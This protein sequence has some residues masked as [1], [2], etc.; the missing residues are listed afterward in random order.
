MRVLM[1]NAFH[2][3]KG[4]VERTVFDETAW[5]GRA[6]HEVAHFAIQDARNVPSPFAKHFAPAADY[7]ESTPAW[8]QL[9]QLPRAI[10]S[11]PAEHALEG[12]LTAWRPDVAHVH[13]PSRYLTP[14]VIAGLERAR[15]PVVMTLHDFKPWC[16]NRVLFARGEV[17]ERCKGGQHWHAVSV[18]CVQRS[19]AKSLVGALEAYDHDRRGAYRPVRRWIAPSQ[20]VRGKA[21]ELGA[22]AA[23]VRVLVHGVT[24]AAPAAAGVPELPER[25]VLY[26]GRLADEKGVRM[27]PALARGIAPTPLVV[28][29]GGPL[30]GW[31]ARHAAAGVRTLGH[32][33]TQELAHVRARSAVVVVPSLF[34]ETF[35]YAVAEAQLDARAVIASRI[36]AL[37]EL[38]EHE[39][40]GLLVSP[41]DEPALVAAARRAL[42]EPAVAQRWGETAR[43]RARAAH[44]P[45]AHTRGLA[46]VYQEAMQG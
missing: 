11:A 6:G 28:A 21:V 30:A 36:G 32:L 22:D 29:G 33:G 24:P 5:L 45:E 46:A 43:A 40:S 4:G 12:L 16:T 23:R 14:S 42:A 2:W 8:R 13:A 35:G 27:L 25:Y 39:V 15:I 18:G 19:R 1:L 9:A 34:P 17:C 7:S 31:L 41:G 3:L 44:D 37:T 10:W 38:V 26:A 20:F